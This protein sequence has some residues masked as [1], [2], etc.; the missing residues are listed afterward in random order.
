M[1]LTRNAI[2]VELG[3]DYIRTARAK[4][5]PEWRISVRHTLRNALSAI[6][7][8]TGLVFIGMVDGVLLI[9]IIFNRPGLGR[10]TF[11]AVI[12]QDF[13]ALQ[14]VILLIAIFTVTIN[15][16]AD[17]VYAWLFPQ[18]RSEILPSGHLH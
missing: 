6:I 18:S 1:R 14:G 2:M 11:N 8:L 5:L 16:A 15:L 7:P 17:L 4:G 12:A 3:R 9:E 13:P 10:Y